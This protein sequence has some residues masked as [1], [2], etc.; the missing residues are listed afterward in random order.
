MTYGGARCSG[1]CDTAAACGGD[2]FTAA[3]TG[4]CG[5]SL[6]WC[7]TGCSPVVQSSIEQLQY[8]NDRRHNR[9][10]QGSLPMR[11]I[12]RTDI[13]EARCCCLIALS[14][15]SGNLHSCTPNRQQRIPL[16]AL[17]LSEAEATACLLPPL[18]WLLCLLHLSFV[19]CYYIFCFDLLACVCVCVK[20]Y[21]CV[22]ALCIASV[23]YESTAFLIISAAL[24]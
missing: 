20:C 3:A 1:D 15:L 2:Y 19:K 5:C 6:V 17:A 16:S 9:N 4:W 22:T 24:L 23:C 8:L 10:P 7:C 18:C 11:E 12:H 14:L 13:L 21:C